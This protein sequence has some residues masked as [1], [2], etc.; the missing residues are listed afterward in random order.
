MQLLLLGQ[1]EA[2][3]CN[4]RHLKR[5][6]KLLAVDLLHPSHNI[7]I[8]PKKSPISFPPTKS[9]SPNKPGV[10]N[11]EPKKEFFETDSIEGCSGPLLA[12]PED[13]KVD[14]GSPFE[15]VGDGGSGGDEGSGGGDYGG[16]DG[17]DDGGGGGGDDDDGDGGGDDDGWISWDEVAGAASPRQGMSCV[18]QT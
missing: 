6:M 5:I 10:T 13:V 17:G 15:G 14:F 8:E 9:A 7:V 18:V 2:L 16:D 12:S 4:A 1:V 11:N 3:P